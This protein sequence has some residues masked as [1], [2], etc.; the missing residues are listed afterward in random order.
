MKIVSRWSRDHRRSLLET[1]PSKSR[2]ARRC[3]H[4]AGEFGSHAHSESKGSVRS[5]NPQTIPKV[6]PSHKRGAAVRALPKLAKQP[7]HILWP[8][9]T[10]NFRTE[11]YGVMEWGHTPYKVSLNSNPPRVIRFLSRSGTCGAQADTCPT[12]EADTP[13]KTTQQT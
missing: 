4:T 8:P 2:E 6:T 3:G 12:G 9:K 11:A 7:V 10:R 5:D 13:H 1:R